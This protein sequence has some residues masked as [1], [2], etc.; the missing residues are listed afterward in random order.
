MA[1]TTAVAAADDD[2]ID[3]KAPATRKAYDIKTKHDFV[4]TIDTLISSGKS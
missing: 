1:N 4:Q 2:V 3:P